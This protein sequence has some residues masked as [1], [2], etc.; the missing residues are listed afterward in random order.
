MNFLKVLVLILLWLAGVFLL[1]VVPG[2][3]MFPDSPDIRLLWSAVGGFVYGLFA[4]PIAFNA[5]DEWAD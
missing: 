5:Y 3:L 1:V 2:R 4:G